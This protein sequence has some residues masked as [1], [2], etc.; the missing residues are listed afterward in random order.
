MSKVI[1]LGALVVLLGFV[2]SLLAVVPSSDAQDKKP[3]PEIKKF[4]KTVSN[5]N[6]GNAGKLLK[7]GITEDSDWATLLKNANAL[8]KLSK[9]LMAED[10]CL[11]GDWAKACA[12]LKECSAK[13]AE[14]AKEKNVDNAK[15]SFKGLTG[16]CAICHKAHRKTAKK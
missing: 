6:C 5:P 16:A 13:L 3:A 4:M 7:K 14:A 12:T 1:R 10:R 8:N 11:S 9:D 15:A 2:L